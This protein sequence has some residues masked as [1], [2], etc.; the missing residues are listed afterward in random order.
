[1]PLVNPEDQIPTTAADLAIVH[2]TVAALEDELIAFRRDLHSHPELGWEEIRT[3]AAVASRLS[4]AGLRVRMLAGSGLVADIGP[5]EPA[6][7]VAL[8]ADLDA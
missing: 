8:R 7:R 3:T 2:E 5:A 1:L 6:Y 4:A